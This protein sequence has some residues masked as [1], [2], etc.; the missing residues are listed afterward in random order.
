MIIC[1]AEIESYPRPVGDFFFLTKLATPGQPRSLLQLTSLPLSRIPRTTQTV[2]PAN[3][4]HIGKHVL[5]WIKH[6]CNTT[7]KYTVYN[8]RPQHRTWSTNVNV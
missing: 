7:T 3:Q 1:K 5:S 4:S 2:T 6:F 8:A